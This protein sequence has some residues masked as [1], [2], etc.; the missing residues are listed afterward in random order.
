VTGA[1]TGHGLEEGVRGPMND[2]IAG[3]Y[4]L[5]S[6]RL[7]GLCGKPIKHY[8]PVVLLIPKAQWYH[9]KCS[10]AHIKYVVR[11]EDAA[12]AL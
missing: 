12:P 5:T 11:G 4:S 7:C 2:S 10:D 1:K 3:K 9:K 8:Q 6:G